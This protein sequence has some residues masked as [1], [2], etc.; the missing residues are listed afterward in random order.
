MFTSLPESNRDTYLRLRSLT[1]VDQ[2]REGENC[3]FVES[4]S[5]ASGTNV[6]VGAHSVS[7]ITWTETGITWNTKP[8]ATDPALSTQTITDNVARWYEFDVTAWVKPQRDGGQP[9]ISPR[10]EEPGDE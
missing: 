2:R 5:D 4:L 8:A 10:A 6:P 7:N 9:I 3:V 1:A